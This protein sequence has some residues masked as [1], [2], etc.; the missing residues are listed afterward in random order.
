MPVQ[1]SHGW[2]CDEFQLATELSNSGEESL[3]VLQ[4]RIAFKLERTICGCSMQN[5]RDG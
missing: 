2:Q 1:N 3:K 5:L 4:G